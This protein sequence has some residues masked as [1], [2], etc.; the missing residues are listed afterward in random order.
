MIRDLSSGRRVVRRTRVES[1]L[2]CRTDTVHHRG[3]AIAHLHFI[4]IGK[5]AL[6]YSHGASNALLSSSTSLSPHSFSFPLP[7]WDY[8]AV[9]SFLDSRPSRSPRL[10]S[11]LHPRFPLSRLRSVSFLGSQTQDITLFESSIAS[12][13]LHPLILSLSRFLG[14]NFSLFTS[15]S[16]ASHR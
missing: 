13:P 9:S 14:T 8:P 12:E 5:P 11:H 15:I 16:P 7:S 1:A 6:L 4:V 10:T 3:L 2:G